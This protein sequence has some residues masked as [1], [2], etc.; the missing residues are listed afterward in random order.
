MYVRVFLALPQVCACVR[1]RACVR[2][3]IGVNVKCVHVRDCQIAYLP[4]YS[5]DGR[6]CVCVL[7]CLHGRTYE[8]IY[9]VLLCPMPRRRFVV[10]V[11]VVGRMCVC[12]CVCVSAVF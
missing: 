12:V 4:S 10:G 2:A 11:A 1:V 5:N 3:R 6:V 8:C 7:H 9:D